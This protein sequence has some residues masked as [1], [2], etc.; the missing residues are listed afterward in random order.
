MS[1][2]KPR[3]RAQERKARNILRFEGKATVRAKNKDVRFNRA[4]KKMHAEN[5]RHYRN[6]QSAQERKLRAKFKQ[7]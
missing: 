4:Q 7:Q 5:A 6:E 2:K 3:K 1:K